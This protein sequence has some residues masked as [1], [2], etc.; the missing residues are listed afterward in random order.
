M[1]VP[2]F[3][4][5]LCLTPD[6]FTQEGESADAWWIKLWLKLLHTLYPYNYSTVQYSTVQYSTVQ[7][8]TV[9][10]STV[11]YSTV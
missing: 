1:Y 9:Q 2:H 6:N 8:S 11:Q 5:L 3:I 7:Y 4:M 10:Y